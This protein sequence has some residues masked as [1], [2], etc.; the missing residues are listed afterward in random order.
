[1]DG[2]E[3]VHAL[4]SPIS[5]GDNRENCHHIMLVVILQNRDKSRKPIQ[6]SY[7]QA[8][9]NKLLGRL[10][11]TQLHGMAIWFVIDFH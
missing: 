5:T 2:K 1:M 11:Q 4:S 9:H 7:M 10:P 8:F 3:H 6:V